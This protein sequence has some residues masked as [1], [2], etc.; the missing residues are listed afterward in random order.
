MRLP[1]KGFEVPVAHSSE[2]PTILYAPPWNP[3]FTLP[4][5]TFPALQIPSPQ[6]LSHMESIVATIRSRNILS[7]SETSLENFVLS[8]ESLYFLDQLIRL[9]FFYTCLL[10]F[11]FNLYFHTSVGQIA[12][13][14][15]WVACQRPHIEKGA[16]SGQDLGRDKASSPL[17]RY[18]WPHIATANT[19]SIDSLIQLGIIL[20]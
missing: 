9:L 17:Q 10:Y 3:A 12:C 2:K 14:N 7:V 15:I 6:I 13:D 11:G 5:W 16:W 18:G 20:I 8:K 19:L 1:L 4:I